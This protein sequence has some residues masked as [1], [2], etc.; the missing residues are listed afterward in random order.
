MSGYY[1]AGPSTAA[2]DLLWTA[3][4][5]M[6][7]DPETGIPVFPED[8][9]DIGEEDL[10]RATSSIATPCGSPVFRAAS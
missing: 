5:G 10:V 4:D 6:L 1:G 7:A 3:P 2:S 9:E 8:L